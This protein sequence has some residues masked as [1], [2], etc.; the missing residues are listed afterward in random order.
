[1]NI[2][3]YIYKYYSIIFLRLLQGASV[4]LGKGV[5]GVGGIT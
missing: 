2:N 5:M 3:K 1:M 4:K